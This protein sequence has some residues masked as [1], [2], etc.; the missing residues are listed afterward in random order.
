V[1]DAVVQYG[2]SEACR[3]TCRATA[4]VGGAVVP[5]LDCFSCTHSSAC[6]SAAGTAITQ[7]EGGAGTAGACGA[8]LHDSGPGATAAPFSSSGSWHLRTVPRSAAEI[9][10]ATAQALR[11]NIDPAVCSFDEL[12]DTA[13]EE[14]APLAAAARAGHFVRDVGMPQRYL[15][16]LDIRPEDN[17]PG[18]RIAPRAPHFKRFLVVAGVL[19]DDGDGW[20]PEAS[21]PA[22]CAGVYAFLREVMHHPTARLLLRCDIDSKMACDPSWRQAMVTL[23]RGRGLT[24]DAAGHLAW[25]GLITDG[26]DDDEDDGAWAACPP[27]AAEARSAARL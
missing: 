24:V 20:I 4:G 23:P 14:D 26:L 10:A 11:N 1:L 27:S 3:T 7:P 22:V 8:G 5:Y 16:L 6:G 9:T 21:Y 19:A 25:A 17:R 13:L 18:I 12:C 15:C 2:H